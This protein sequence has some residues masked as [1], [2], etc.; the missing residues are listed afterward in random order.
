M[1]SHPPTVCLCESWLST[2]E[3]LRFRAEATQECL[4]ELGFSGPSRKWDSEAFPVFESLV[5]F[6]RPDLSIRDK[7]LHL[8]T[9]ASSG[10]QKIPACAPSLVHS[11]QRPCCF[12]L[13][14]QSPLQP[15]ARPSWQ[16]GA[17]NHLLKP[18]VKPLPVHLWP[19]S[20]THPTDAETGPRKNLPWLPSA[21]E[22]PLLTV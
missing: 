21:K 5:K 22:T 14:G 9:P 8:I 17:T 15:L 10:I 18:E 4:E 13:Q 20:S 12:S 7:S 1:F 16:T 6:E 19:G 11:R 2:I 3:K